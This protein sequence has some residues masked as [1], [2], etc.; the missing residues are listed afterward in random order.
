MKHNKSFAI[1]ITNKGNLNKHTIF[2]KQITKFKIKMN[3]VK[4]FFC[5]AKKILYNNKNNRFKFNK[6]KKLKN[7]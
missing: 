1:Y 4:I 5:Q 2:L 3:L 6:L 7:R